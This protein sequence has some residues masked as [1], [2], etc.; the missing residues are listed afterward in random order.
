MERSQLLLLFAIAF[1]VVL[2]AWGIYT[3]VSTPPA[4]P[5]VAP[6]TQPTLVDRLRAE[7][8]RRM[9]ERGV[10]TATAPAVQ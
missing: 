9:K 6:T 4:A 5:Q 2:I 3:R 1:F 8:E 10:T 7:R